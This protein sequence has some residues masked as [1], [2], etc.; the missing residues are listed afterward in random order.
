MSGTT[1]TSV[2][3]HAEGLTF[4]MYYSTQSQNVLNLKQLKSEH[5]TSAVFKAGIANLIGFV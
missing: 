3:D 1:G 5:Q 2:W 4:A